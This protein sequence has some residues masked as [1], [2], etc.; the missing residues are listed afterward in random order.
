MNK[1]DVGEREGFK[2]VTAVLLRF[3]APDMITGRLQDVRTVLLRRTLLDDPAFAR[4]KG[5]V[6]VRKD[7]IYRVLGN[8]PLEG[9]RR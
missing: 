7:E 3:E 5:F 1:E 2:P 8:N 4:I 9:L 6:I